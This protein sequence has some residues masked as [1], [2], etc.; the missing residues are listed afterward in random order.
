VRYA[1]NQ[2]HTLEHLCRY[3]T[4]P[5]VANERLTLNRAGQGVLTL[6]TPYRD[7]TTPIVMSPLEFMLVTRYIPAW[8]KRAF[9]FPIPP[10]LEAS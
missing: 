10:H 7:G 4:R 5:T 2:R 9:V 6:K 3:I 1:I 8:R